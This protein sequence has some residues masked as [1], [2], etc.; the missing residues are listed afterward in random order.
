MFFFIWQPIYLFNVLSLST[1]YKEVTPTGQLYSISW[2]LLYWFVKKMVK[3]NLGYSI[4][5]IPIPSQKSYLLQLMDKIEMMIKRMRRKAIH[6]SDNEDYINKTEW[7]GL[8]SLNSP[9]TK[10]EITPFENEFVSLIKNIKFRKVRNDFQDQLQ[11]DLKRTKASN[12]TTTFADK[13]ANIYRLTKE[14]YDQI[15][16][17]SITA[18]YKKVS[19][20]IKKKINAA[21]KQVLRNNKVLKRLQTNKE[22]KL[23]HIT[24]RPQRKFPKWSNCQAD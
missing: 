11:Q 18:T 4:K 17:D 24:E 8:K 23:L 20:S 9:R 12:K 14:E 3:V 19:H 22:N 6:F 1:I 5:N 16:N 15:L 13:T 2:A 10:K 7:Y 21:G